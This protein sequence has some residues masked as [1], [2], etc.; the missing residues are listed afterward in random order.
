[1][2]ASGTPH[3]LT[4]DLEDWHQL[5]NRRITGSTVPPSRHVVADTHRVLDI[6]DEAGA[7]ATFFVVGAVGESNPDLVRE[8]AGRGHEIG[9][10]TYFHEP[11][12]RLRADEFKADVSRS[13]QQLQDLTGQPVLGFRA[14]EFSVGHL[15]HWSFRVLAEVGFAYDSSVFPTTAAR[16]GIP[17]A[18]LS[19]FPIETAGGTLWEF[20]L[21]TWDLGRR[22]LPAAGG[23]YFRLLPLP[24]LRCA[25]SQ[26]EAARRPAVLYFHPYEFH[27][28]WLYLSGLSWR[29]R[30]HAANVRFSL[31][32]NVGTAAIE[33]RLRALLRGFA[34]APLGELYRRHSGRAQDP[35][36]EALATART[37]E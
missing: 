2:S 30:L 28:G 11:I 26:A 21:A 1:L 16:Y 34:F 5:L 22:R 6:L 13:R 8:V 36:P 32:H 25:L 23:S 27:R 19:P 18:P 20:P 3:A 10:H 17:D 24:A 31:L 35:G 9:S 14:P 4:V 12:S 15:A 37:T 33:A 7:R 29:E